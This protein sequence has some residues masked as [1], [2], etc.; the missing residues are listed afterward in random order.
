MSDKPIQ[1]QFGQAIINSVAAFARKDLDDVATLSGTL[2]SHVT[3]P[4][5][6]ATLAET[7]YGARWIYK[8]GLALL[9]KDEEQMAHVR[10]QLIDYGA[11]CEGLLVDLIAHS[12]TR[13]HMTGE[14]Y[15]FKDVKKLQRPINW[16][17]KDIQGQVT[18]QTFFWQIAVAE[19]ENII[20]APTIKRL[21]SLRDD[22]NTVH[23]AARTFKA[24][25]GRSHAA[26]ETL[27][28]VITE[29]KAWKA[30]NP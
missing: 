1:E 19:E 29:A 14:R 9:V 6:R 5:L 3:D 21:H 28:K 4:T 7:L 30:A 10:T 15:K 26:F 17:V 22:R 16:A 13:G 2:F 18:R 27:R 11:V 8:L 23:M 24:Y 12:I 25:L 20:S